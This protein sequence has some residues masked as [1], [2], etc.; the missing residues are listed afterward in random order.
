M[1]LGVKTLAIVALI[2]LVPTVARAQAVIAGSVRDTSGAVLPGVTVEASSP[3]LIE[4]VRTTISDGSGQYRIEDLRPGVYKV[5]FTLPGFSTFEREGV[6]LT[7]SFTATINA[8]MRV[9]ALEETVTVTGES[10]IVDVQSARRQTVL[11]NDVLKAIPTVRSYNAL[12]VVVPGVVTNTNDVAT[13]TATTQFPIHGGRNN[14][15]R[16][17]VDGLN[18]G[19]PPGG[20]QPPGFSVDVGNSEEISFTTSGG[21]G[22]S[23]TGG[24][25]MNVV[26]KT[27]GNTLHGSAFYSGSGKNLQADNT[28]GI[29]GIA[30]PTPL[31]KIY[32]LNGAVGGPI[33]RDKLWYFATARTQGSTRVNA[34]MFYNLNSGDPTKWLYVG[35]PGISEPGFSD[36]T[37][38][39][40][41]GRITW[42]VTP[43]N[44]FGAYW[45]EQWV[46]RNCRGATIGITTPPVASPEAIGPGQTLPLRVP[47]V[48]W[49][50]PVTNRLLFDAGFGG[51]YYGWGN[52]EREDN[53]TR[54]LIRVTE[55]CA[56]G[57]ANNGGRPDL[58]YRSQ[59]WGNNHTGSYTW[60]ASMSYVT[61]RHSFKVGYQGTLMTDDRTWYSNNNDL[62]YRFNNGIPN[63]LTQTISP[64]VNDA[65]AGW[66]AVYAQEQFTMGRLTLQGAL[67]FDVAKSWFPEQN[68]GPDRFLPVAFHFPETKG[69]D[70]YKD[71]T[72][73]MGAAIDVFGNGRTAVKVNLGKYLE[74]VGVSTTYANSNP[75]L[76]V[77]RTTGPFGVV[78]AS[79]TW[80]DADGDLVA[81]CDFTNP[82]AHGNAAAVNGGG[83]ADFCGQ[84]SNTRFGQPVLTGNYDPD[85]LSGWGVRPSDWSF[86]VSVQQQL[87]QRM[88]LEVGYYRR[89]FDGFTLN[90]N[91]ALTSADLTPYSIVAP[92][93]PRLPDGGGYTISGLYNVVPS[94]SGQ[95]DDLSTVASKYGEWYQYF[96]GVDITLN[97]RTQGGLTLQGGTSTGQNVADNCDVRENLPELSVGIGA[98]LVGSNVSMTS[99]YCHVAYGWLTQLRGL[100][101]YVIPKI[102]AQVSAVFQSKP[103]ALLSANYAMPAADVA[104]FLGRPP[105]GNV[106]NV[107]FNLIEPG[108]MYGDRINQLDLRIAK[109]LRFGSTR[110]MVSVDLYN[111]MNASAILTYNQNFVPNGTWLQANSVLTGRLAR[112]SVDFSF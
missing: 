24:L 3:A 108:S 5:T 15:G 4:K 8:D 19:N 45:D 76:R 55:Q 57:C 39:N 60:K 7:G 78:G 34:N 54:D 27:G 112:I 98:G 88:S 42:Q 58:V 92:L 87:M 90:D 1:R 94:K 86:G 68:I 105:S 109:N 52:F 11:N 77:P 26:P 101:S 61:G 25:V 50:S 89:W 38:D 65:R 104:R 106:P 81:D 67:R 62:W 23:E 64:W 97:L 51:T 36:R 20:N 80:I 95:V 79:R 84:L 83:G 22:E 93:D 66:D 46:C 111:V 72:P 9:G 17:T 96:N 107:T 48:T 70:S 71:I 13:G 56:A 102:D 30:A 21:L 2:I 10:P 49:N 85:L 47:Q 103:G 63:Q 44:K 6:E 59:D 33:L 31:T 43:R 29:A 32:D 91:L 53:A 37:W 40:I 100:G 75:T 14:E 69:V 35:G 28:E 12:V 16:M 74:G 82:L 73:R 41:S 110:S 99:P 18:I